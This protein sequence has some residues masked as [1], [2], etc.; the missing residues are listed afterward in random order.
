MLTENLLTINYPP[1]F[2]TAEKTLSKDTITNMSN[3]NR[4]PTDN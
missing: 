1:I 3:V 4:K 2:I